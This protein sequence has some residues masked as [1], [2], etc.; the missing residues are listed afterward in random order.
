MC[1]V[2][3]IITRMNIIFCLLLLSCSEITGMTLQA[4]HSYRIED[5]S[6]HHTF[7]PCVFPAQSTE[8]T[9]SPSSSPEAKRWS[10]WFPCGNSKSKVDDSTE[11]AS[12]SSSDLDSGYYT[13]S[14][15]LEVDFTQFHALIP[16]PLDCLSCPYIPSL[17]VSV[18]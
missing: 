13:Q 16:A 15:A 11:H 18:N 12:V 4:R 5:I 10:R 1:I 6:F 7:A 3:I 8:V 17:A 14:P 2:A 9:A